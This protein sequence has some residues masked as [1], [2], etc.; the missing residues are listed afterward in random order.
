MA[1]CLLIPPGEWGA[2]IAV[3]S[4]QRFGVP[5]G[6]GG[7]HAAYL[8]C[9]DKLVRKMPGRLI[10]VSKDAQGKTALRMAIQTREPALPVLGLLC[11]ARA[12]DHVVVGLELRHAG[13]IGQSKVGWGAC[14][15]GHFCVDDKTISRNKT[16]LHFSYCTVAYR[17]PVLYSTVLYKAKPGR[18]RASTL[19]VG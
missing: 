13:Q 10:G 2:D 16:S 8:A 1:L 14:A 15:G 18:G 5:M 11:V 4:T 19:R 9:K 3:G 7:P 17:L 6:Y 12:H